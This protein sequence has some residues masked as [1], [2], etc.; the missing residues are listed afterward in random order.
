MAL[1]AALGDDLD[2]P[3]RPR[4][5]P[6]HW[7]I[8]AAAEPDPALPP[9][10]SRSAPRRRRP[11]E[12]ARRLPRSAS[13]RGRRR[14]ACSACCRPGQRLVSREGDLWRWDGFVAAAQGA[15]AAASRLAE[16]SRLGLL[17]EQEADAAPQRR[18][19]TQPLPRRRPSASSRGAGRGAAPAPAVARGP[20]QAGPDARG[21]D[22]HG[23]AGARDRGQARRRR[24][25]Q[26]AQ[27]RRRWS[28]PSELLA[29]D[30]ELP[31]QA[32]AGMEALEAELAAAQ[33]ET[34]RAAPQRQPRPAPSS[35]RSSASIAP[36]PSASR[37]SPRRTRALADALGRRR[38][39][40]RDPR[41][42]PRR[43]RRRRSTSSPACRPWSSSSARSCM[44]R[45][46]R[47][48][49][50]SA[51]PPPTRWPPPT[52]AHRAG[53]AGAARRASRRRRRARGARAHRGAAGE[54]ARSAAARRARK[55]RDQLGCAPEDCLALAELAP[56]AP[57]PALERRD[58]PARRGSRPTASAWAASTCRPT[59]I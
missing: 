24:R 59:R 10:S 12:L 27:R 57:L 28:K 15:T 49:G 1:A 45:A 55:I 5:R 39:A 35:S 33:A 36:A 56:T 6:V 58:R 16:R 14:R 41:G 30:R 3:R 46:G 8:N 32:L 11:P 51:R 17:A 40:D 13:W 23:A 42:A 50:A 22:R 53:R 44:T 7:R 26:A 38:A 9:A 4:R 25:R 47:G 34:S 18:D 2:A 29:E 48:R 19:R 21:A 52:A 37:P 54:R 43:G 20:G 31:C